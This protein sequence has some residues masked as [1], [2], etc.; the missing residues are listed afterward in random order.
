MT[1]GN[2]LLFVGI[3]VVIYMMRKGGG[4]CGGHNHGGNNDHGGHGGS[5]KSNGTGHTH[6][7]A[8]EASED[9]A[10]TDPVCIDRKSVV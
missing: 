5:G 9:K 8:I 10:E 1:L 3:G 4:C 2:I 6:P 7:R